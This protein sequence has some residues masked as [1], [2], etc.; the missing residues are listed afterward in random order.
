MSPA[1]DPAP[2]RI[3]PLYTAPVPGVNVW[4]VISLASALLTLG[5][6]ALVAGVLGYHGY[7]QDGKRGATA[8]ILGIGLGIVETMFWFMV[9]VTASAVRP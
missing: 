9:L 1:Y 7:E 2:G 4:A 8:S 3:R 5:P 6:L